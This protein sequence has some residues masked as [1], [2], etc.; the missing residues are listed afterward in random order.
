MARI[1]VAL[2]LMPESKMRDEITRDVRE[3][4]ALTTVLL[5]RERVRHR[6]DHLEAEAVDLV[7]VLKG[8]LD[9]FAGRAPGVAVL[10]SPDQ[11]E[12]NVDADLIKV[13]VHNLV[14]NALKFSTP[15]SKQVL[16]QLSKAH[17]EV[18]IKI[19]DDGCG[20]PEDQAQRVLEPFVK[21]DPA[22]G[23]RTGYG[24]GL[25]LCQ[26]IVQAHK[27]KITISQGE[28]SGTVVEVRFPLI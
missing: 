6:T 5:E 24:L 27:G 12:A 16:V 19:E 13:L 11:L 2:E 4:E 20:I 25:N 1:K 17:D 18:L 10:D 26:R 9:G 23:H 22:R 28:T 8:T 3:M 7:P 14:D 21:L 15:D